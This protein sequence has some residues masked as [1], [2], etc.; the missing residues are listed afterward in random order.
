LVTCTRIMR[1]S[2]SLLAGA[3]LEG[4]IAGEL[5]SGHG[6]GVWV[7]TGASTG[8]DVWFVSP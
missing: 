8:Q 7:G 6:H 4:S 2:S 5:A 1:A 3:C